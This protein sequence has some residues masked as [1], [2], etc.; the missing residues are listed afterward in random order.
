[1]DG[2]NLQCNLQD[3]QF[4]PVSDAIYTTDFELQEDKEIVMEVPVKITGTP[5][6]YFRRSFKLKPTVV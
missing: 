3:I 6:V 5:G 4:H 1:V 2:E